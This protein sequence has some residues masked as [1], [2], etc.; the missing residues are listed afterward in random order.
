V[1]RSSGWSRSP[2]VAARLA[3]GDVLVCFLLAFLLWLAPL[4]CV[5]PASAAEQVRIGVA[6]TISDVGYYVADA[7]GFFGQEGLE[8]SI[9]PFNSAAQM[10]AP[11]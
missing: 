6:R 8:V 4:A 1:S 5:S 9:V 11:N 2:Q 10:V 7:K 3:P